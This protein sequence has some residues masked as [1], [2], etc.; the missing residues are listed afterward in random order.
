MRTRSAVRASTRWQGE[1]IGSTFTTQRREPSMGATPLPD[2]D[3]RREGVPPGD[4]GH[5][6]ETPRPRRC[7]RTCCR[8]GGRAHRDQ[9]RT[10]GGGRPTAGA[11]FVVPMHYAIPGLNAARPAGSF[12]RDGGPSAGPQAKLV[13]ASSGEYGRKSS[14]AEPKTGRFN[15]HRFNPVPS[16]KPPWRS[17]CRST[18]S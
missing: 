12:L 18:F 3:R 15:S 6:L 7:R 5:R 13:Q 9:L 17:E 10:G 11:R 16:V 4:L 14:C 1:V 8:S 2:R